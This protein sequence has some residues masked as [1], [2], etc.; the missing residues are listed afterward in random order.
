MEETVIDEDFSIFVDPADAGGGPGDELLGLEPEV[1]LLLGG[2]DRVGAVADVA[3]DLKRWKK[4]LLHILY[5]Y[6]ESWQK[7][8]IWAGVIITIFCINLKVGPA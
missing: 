6:S 8:S 4:M 1:D 2:L 3:A 5:D 7:T